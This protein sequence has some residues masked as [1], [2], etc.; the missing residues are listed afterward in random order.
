MVVSVLEGQLTRTW[1]YTSINTNKTHTI[2]L[3]HDTISGIRSAML[4]FEEI[5]NSIGNSTIFMSSSGHRIPF[6]IDEFKAYI[7]IRKVG[8]LQGFSYQCVVNNQILAEITQSVPIDQDRDIYNIHINNTIHTCDVLKS[9]GETVC[10]YSV[11]TIRIDDD[12]STSVH[13]YVMLVK[14]ISLCLSC[15]LNLHIH[16]QHSL[17]VIYY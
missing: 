13:R 9:G 3:F 4:N 15:I 2:T 14:F 1:L 7:E 10:W 11:N 8:W 12:I 17:S 6:K 16:I 5:Q